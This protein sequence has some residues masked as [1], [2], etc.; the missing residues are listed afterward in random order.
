MVT[1]QLGQGKRN[2]KAYDQPSASAL[3]H[4]GADLSV[5]EQG[6]SRHPPAWSRESLCMWFVCHLLLPKK[7]HLISTV[8]T[9]AHCS[10]F[11]NVSTVSFSAN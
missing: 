11:S 5:N 2:G 9:G 6:S 10:H 7:S 1:Q 3:E 4:N 8:S